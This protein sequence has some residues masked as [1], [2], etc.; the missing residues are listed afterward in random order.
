MCDVILVPCSIFDKFLV[1]II[2]VATVEFTVAE[3]GLASEG[4]WNFSQIFAMANTRQRCV[5]AAVVC[6][7]CVAAV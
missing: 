6:G 3:N 4:A 5:V 1:W 2:T 7:S